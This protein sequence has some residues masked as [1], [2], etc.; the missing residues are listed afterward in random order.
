MPI[1]EDLA[2]IIKTANWASQTRNLNTAYINN[3]KTFSKL[4]GEFY[5][6]MLIFYDGT[7]AVFDKIGDIGYAG[8]TARSVIV[9]YSKSLGYD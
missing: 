4:N 9:S 3:L 5:G 7:I 2:K 8:I 1:N 6:Y